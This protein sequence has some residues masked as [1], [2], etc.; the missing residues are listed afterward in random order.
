MS[1]R[2][3][4]PGCPLTMVGPLVALMGILWFWA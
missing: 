4:R 1:E 3:Q 2:S